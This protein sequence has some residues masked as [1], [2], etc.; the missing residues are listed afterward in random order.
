M[1]LPPSVNHTGLRADRAVPKPCLS[2][3][4]NTASTPGAPG[5]DAVHAATGTATVTLRPSASSAEASCRILCPPRQVKVLLS[6]RR[7]HEN[8]LLHTNAEITMLRSD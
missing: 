8:H 4:V 5:A 2:A 1:P 6:A 7:R 3:G